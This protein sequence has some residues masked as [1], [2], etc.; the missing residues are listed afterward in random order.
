MFDRLLRD[1][2]IVTTPGAGF[3]RCGEGYFRIS[4]FNSRANVEEV[5]TRL[6]ALV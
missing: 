2:Q 1:A 5:V 6:K 4:A 3:G